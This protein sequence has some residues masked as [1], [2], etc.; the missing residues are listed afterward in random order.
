MSAPTATST[1]PE[2]LRGMVGLRGRH[3][4]E[5]RNNVGHD[6]DVFRADPQ[7]L[8]EDIREQSS[9]TFA[10]DTLGV[11]VLRSNKLSGEDF[12]G[13]VAS[14]EET[15]D[16]AVN[17]IK[18][19]VID[20]RSDRSRIIGFM[21]RE[22]EQ[23]VEPG[24]MAQIMAWGGH[25][26]RAAQDA[27]YTVCGEQQ[28]MVMFQKQVTSDR[29]PASMPPMQSQELVGQIEIPGPVGPWNGKDN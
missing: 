21:I 12:L 25:M 5:S 17:D 18:I 27:G 6:Y 29:S 19:D 11:V 7:E 4:P 1:S 20:S 9:L 2:I 16:P 22:V 24:N 26:C 28:G 15:D 10:E 14:L 3:A 13:V 23:G 8:K